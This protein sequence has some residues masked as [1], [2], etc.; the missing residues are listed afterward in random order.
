MTIFP[1][2]Q[3]QQAEVQP[4]PLC[5]DALWDPEKGVPVFRAGSPVIAQGAGAVASWC[6]RALATCRYRHELYT[7]DYGSELETLTG[8]SYT[9]ALKQAEARRYVEEALAPNPYI[10]AA[11]DIQTEFDDKGRLTIRCTVDTVYGPIEIGGE[12]FGG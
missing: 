6:W 10:L 11:R 1:I 9:A 4:L 5:R 8:Q 3:P 7:W 12:R 2:I